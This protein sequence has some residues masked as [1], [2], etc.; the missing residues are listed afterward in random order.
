MSYKIVT[1]IFFFLLSLTCVTGQDKLNKPG[2]T[3]DQILDQIDIYRGSDKVWVYLNAYLALAEKDND[4]EETSNAYKEMLHEAGEE[5]R[6]RYADSMVTAAVKS[7]DNDVIG[8]AYLTKGILFYQ[9]KKHSLAL[10]NFLLSNRFLVATQDEYLKFK[11]KYHI[12]LI[13]LYL[14]Y[15]N[16]AI[17]LFNEC[18]A[19]FRE[20][21]PLPYLKSLH[22]LG[23]CYTGIRNIEKSSEVNSLALRECARLKV[24]ELVPNIE[25]SE[26]INHYF[27]KQYRPAIKRLEYAVPL[28]IKQ[29][30]FSNEAVGY[31]YLG[32]SYYAMGD[33]G[34]AM[35]YFHKVD[36]I[37]IRK[38]YIRPDLREN[39]ELLIDHYKSTGELRTELHYID[40]LLK[41]DSVLNTQYKYLSQKVH[42]EYDTQKLLDEKNRIYED[43]AEKQWYNY[44]FKIIIVILILVVGY[45]VYRQVAI[46]RLYRKRFEELMKETAPAVPTTKTAAPVLSTEVENGILAKL[47][48]FE[49]SNGFRKKDLSVNKLAETFDTNYKYLS[50][51]IH[52]HRNKNFIA[53]INDLRVDYIVMKLKEEPKLRKY[54]NGALAEEAGF[55]TAQHFVTA[56]KKK[57]GMPPGYFVDGLNKI[58]LEER[59]MES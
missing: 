32:K 58:A 26:G 16:E 1:A 36:T 45:F 24:P 47:D 49:Q 52:E 6:V 17:S 8:S 46:R 5:D 11:V 2:V 28:I 40:K 39:Y 29:E 42:K 13:K 25:H 7:H 54:T 12:G 15:Y 22:A 48:K 35:S 30:D 51:I 56:F 41:V 55:S 50:R 33:V 53:Y 57:A 10:D 37:F 34:R 9:Q 18:E 27:L 4:W 21:Q 59:T 20:E 43:L 31:F 14:G 44:L 38:G 23:V 19:F 3:Y